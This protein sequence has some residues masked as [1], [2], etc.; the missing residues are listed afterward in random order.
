MRPASWLS[1]TLSNLSM[2]E[3]QY[4]ESPLFQDLVGG[5]LPFVDGAA[6]VSRAP[7]LGVELVPDVVAAIEVK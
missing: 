3:V 1:A 7:G 5:A 2:L 6:P 4:G